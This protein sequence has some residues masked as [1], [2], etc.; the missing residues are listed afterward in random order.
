MLTGEAVV[1]SMMMRYGTTP[2]APF[3]VPFYQYQP[4]SAQAGLAQ[5][6]YSQVRMPIQMV[7]HEYDPRI[8]AARL[9]WRDLPLPLS[10][11]ISL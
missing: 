3:V 7:L 5:L 10:A 9:S 8:T 11:G 1:S 2:E 4:D 6:W